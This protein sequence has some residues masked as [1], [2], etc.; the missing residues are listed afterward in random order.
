[1]S[2]A[3]YTENILGTASGFVTN[4][5]DL[6]ST[7]LYLF[8]NVGTAGAWMKWDFR[9]KQKFLSLYAYVYVKDT[10]GGSS[11]IIKLQGSQDG[12]TWTELNTGTSDGAGGDKFFNFI[13]SDIN[14]RY[15][16]LLTVAGAGAGNIAGC[17]IMHG[18]V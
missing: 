5:Y 11:V 10:G 13:K 14:Y 17:Y 15:I 4:V 6:D 9:R 1:M 3:A 18:V 16:R 12:T 8:Q 2:S 7:T